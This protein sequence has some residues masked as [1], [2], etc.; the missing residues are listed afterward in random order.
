MLYNK[1]HNYNQLNPLKEIWIGGVYPEKFYSHFDSRTQEAFGKITELTN[2]DLNKLQ[3]VLESLG[4][5]VVRPEFQ[6]SVDPYLDSQ[7]NLLKPPICPCDWALVID[8]NLYI[9]PQFESGIEP[10]QHAIDQYVKAGQNVKIINRAYDPMSWLTFSSVVRLGQD[11]IMDYDHRVPQAEKA[12]YRVARQLARTHRVHLSQ[13]GD[14]NDGVFNPLK[15]GHI[16][17]T[18][19]IKTYD[20]TFP[21]WQVFWVNKT[22]NKDNFVYNPPAHMKWW[23]PGVNFAHYNR[24]ILKIADSWL[25]NPHESIFEVNIIIVDENNIITNL[26]NEETLKYFESVGVTPH[27]VDFAAAY[28]WD[29]GLHCLSS[30]IFRTGETA[31]YWPEREK[32]GIFPIKEWYRAGEE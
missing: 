9:I 28:F 15:P 32:T 7:D 30:D 25:G 31:D 2:R 12:A 27:I 24:E 26:Q 22:K 16:F 8:N 20:Q 5:S 11:I 1:V 18:S 3:Q 10:F 21:G 29:S 6:D 4:V 17:S 19:Y 14:H 23:L 13:T